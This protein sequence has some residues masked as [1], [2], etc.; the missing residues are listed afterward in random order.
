MMQPSAQ[1]NQADTD[2]FGDVLSCELPQPVAFV[3]STLPTQ[4][5]RA[6]ATLRAIAQMEDLRTEESA[7]ERGELPQLVQRMDAKLDL[8]LA[9]I[10][11]LV[12][13][14]EG[15]LPLHAVRWSVHGIR[16][17]A[18]EAATTGTRGSVRLQPSDWLPEVIELPATVIACAP[19]PAGGHS[20]WLRFHDLSP[21]LEEALDRHLFRLHRRQIAEARRARTSEE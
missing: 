4:Q 20:L 6:E 2:L 7:D 16:I 15:S 10:A 18:S 5:S 1:G 11:R 9:L 14:S 12:R 8:T 3:A 19:S 17:D 21:A 13:Q